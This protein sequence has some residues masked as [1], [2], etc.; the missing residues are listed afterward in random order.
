MP[1]PTFAPLPTRKNIFDFV[2]GVLAVACE[3]CVGCLVCV[4][5]AK[6]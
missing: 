5:A 1:S 4:G 3:Q 2:C 6:V